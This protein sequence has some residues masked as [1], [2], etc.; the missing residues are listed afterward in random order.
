MNK[1]TWHLQLLPICAK[2]DYI[3]SK[4]QP[5]VKL[6]LRPGEGTS[7]SSISGIPLKII[8]IF[9]TNDKITFINWI[10]KSTM[11]NSK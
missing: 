10:C 11:K 7:C 9:L 8:V 4:F 6:V 5:T 2:N 1:N 3:F